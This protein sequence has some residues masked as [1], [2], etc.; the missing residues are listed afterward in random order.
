MSYTF[1][2]WL[3]LS[4]LFVMVLSTGLLMSSALG[5]SY[6]ENVR[7]SIAKLH[8]LTLIVVLFAGF[9][10]LARA[11]IDGAF[12]KGWFIF[13]LVAWLLFGMLPLFMKKVPKEHQG[14]LIL[15]YAALL[16]ATVYMVTNQPF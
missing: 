2:K 9:G 16:S 13:K 7:K 11:N 15:F 4:S 1:Y 14:K 6:K 5:Q 3:H 8:G 12:G 10:L